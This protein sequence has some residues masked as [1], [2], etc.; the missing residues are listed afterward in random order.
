MTS[1]QLPA[2]IIVCLIGMVSTCSVAAQESP[3]AEPGTDVDLGTGL[4]GSVPWS[5]PPLTG[6]WGGT[7]ADWAANGFTFGFDVT[8]IYQDLVDGGVEEGGENGGAYYLEAQIDTGKAGWWQGAFIELRLE[9][10]YG[11]SIAGQTGTLF[12]TNNLALF[13]LD[14]QDTTP[15]ISKLMLTQF[16]SETFGVAIGRTDTLDGDLNHFA[17]GRGKTQ[18]MNPAFS[19]TLAAARTTPYV[20][21]GISAFFVTG[22]PFM[23]RPGVLTIGGGDATV[24][25]DEAFGDWDEL[26][27]FWEYRLP[28]RFFDLPGSSVIGMTYNSTDVVDLSELPRPPLLP[29]EVK[30]ATSS[31]TA[32]FNLHQYLWVAAG[33]DTDNAGYDPHTPLLRGVGMFF[34]F[35]LGD[36]DTNPVDWDL[37]IGLGGRGLFPG[38]GNDTYG[39]GYYTVERSDS[40]TAFLDDQPLPPGITDVLFRSGS[41]GFEAWYNM[42]VAS[43]F[44]LTVDYQAVQSTIRPIDTSHVLGFRFKIDL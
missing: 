42:E 28:T 12:G 10:W 7:R 35:G 40:V 19:W 31:A 21:N 32:A 43:W 1:P 25:P 39:I 5:R 37:K 44:H 30:K 4:L 24:S 29:G 9:G 18:F 2:C 22:N 41:S 27:A 16:F 26:F 11:N 38:R 20:I 36:K 23:E 34:R 13:P 33:Q 6:D 14:G 8:N 15:V 17:S 3:P